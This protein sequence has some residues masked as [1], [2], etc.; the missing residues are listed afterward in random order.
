MSTDPKTMAFASHEVVRALAGGGKTYLLSSRYI[1]LL[2]AEATPESILAVTFTRKAAGEIFQRILLRLADAVLNDG[3]RQELGRS[4]G[5]GTL[6]AAQCEQMLVSL[7]RGIHVASIS[8]IDSFF[9]R[10]VQSL[11]VVPEVPQNAAILG[12]DDPLVDQIRM[13]AIGRT[14]APNPDEETPLATLQSMLRRFHGGGA[15]R[16]VT[17]AIHT[18]VSDFYDLYRE[19]P[20]AERWRRLSVPRGLLDAPRLAAAVEALRGLAAA[21]PLTKAGTPRRNWDKAYS[22]LTDAAAAAQWRV[23]LGHTLVVRLLAGDAIYNGLPVPEA[24]TVVLQ[25]LIDHARSMELRRLGTKTEATHALLE[26][27]HGFF[28]AL[29]HEQGIMLFNDLTGLLVDH[30]AHAQPAAWEDLYFRLD[31]M[32]QHLLV[33]EFQDT[34]R[35]QWAVLRPMAEEITAHHDGSR[36]FF[37]VGDLKQAIY[38][39]RGGCADILDTLENDLHLPANTREAL[40][41]SYRS[42]Q[43]VLD[44]VNTVFSNLHT[45]PALAEH[46][47]TVQHWQRHWHRHEA[48]RQRAGFVTLVCPEQEAASRDGTA[49]TDESDFVRAA[50][51]YVAQV[52]RAAPAASVGV[53][54]RDNRTA[55]RLLD[56]LRESDVAASGEGGHPLTD[57]PAVNTILAALTLADRPSDSIAAF[58]LF[59]TP[60]AALLNLSTLNR[61]AAETVATEIRE[62]LGAAGYAHTL[63][64]WADALAPWCDAR[65]GRR[66]EQLVTLAARSEPITTLRPIQFVQQV[67]MTAVEDP[68][69]SPVRVMTIH[70]A[71]GLEFD[72]VV[73]PQLDTKLGAD[74]GAAY[75]HRDTEAGPVEAVYC[76]PAAWLRAT[77]PQLATAAAEQEARLLRDDLCA[78][79]VA[80]TRPRHALHMLVP[81][82]TL[83]RDGTTAAH[84]HTDLSSA[85]ILRQALAGDEGTDSLYRHGDPNWYATLKAPPSTRTPTPTP[86][87]RLVVPPM[88]RRRRPRVTPS[89]LAATDTIYGRDLL[90]RHDHLG[91]QR[92]IL[93]HLWFEMIEW[94]D[95]VPGVPTAD[96]LV[97]AACRSN[98]A[99]VPATVES[100]AASFLEGLSQPDVA[101]VMSHATH[102]E[103]GRDLVVWREQPFVIERRGQLVSGKFDRVV[104]TRDATRV[105]TVHLYDFKTDQVS[106]SLEST[107]EQYRGQIEAYVDALHAM[108]SP[109]PTRVVARLVFTSVGTTWTFA[110]KERD[111]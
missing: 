92:G 62:Q 104:F 33:D 56:H 21:I 100:L 69:F 51:H 5:G 90:H 20:E 28:A 82:L 24:W 93:M 4:I 12:G 42:S 48:A 50:A 81:P 9:N 32:V 64:L 59:H 74:R 106:T 55:Q 2:R 53:L 34:S 111:R 41:H 6:S 98:P 97:A 78:L 25:P 88:P 91:M 23:F 84:G 105:G 40:R 103:A 8:T 45:N 110:T 65:G 30:L 46:V 14:I 75:V 80:M 35:Q 72:I 89:Q 61:D 44:A 17:A 57:D 73:L 1:A 54:T 36:T 86:P 96:R 19:A 49:T 79:Y 16:S 37:C 76:R 101:A 70:K 60:L 47:E 52:H 27:F 94:V 13:A 109:A 11:G 77:S 71:K 107:A 22:V 108:F 87:V 43:V 29:R 15:S 10:I 7:C 63:G 102:A 85:A 83:R 31:A 58:H 38:A 39:W 18:A 95:Q 99:L 3:A 66:L 68:A 26:R 67:E